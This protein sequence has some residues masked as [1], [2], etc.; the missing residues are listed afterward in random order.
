M[1][2]KLEEQITTA[3]K[4]IEELEKMTKDAVCDETI[5][6]RAIERNLG[7]IAV[8]VKRISKMQ[9]QWNIPDLALWLKLKTYILWDMKKLKK[10][11][12]DKV[13]NSSVPKI[14]TFLTNKIS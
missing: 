1:D 13:I 9:P 6:M 7:V 12:L 11:F 8:S 14:K 4:A 2:S 5:L 3:L 10:S